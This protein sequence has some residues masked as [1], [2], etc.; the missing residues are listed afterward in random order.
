MYKE[1]CD[2]LGQH[3]YLRDHSHL[4]TF[5]AF[6]TPMQISCLSLH[7]YVTEEQIYR[8]LSGSQRGLLL[9]NRERLSKIILWLT[10]TIHIRQ[11]A[12]I[13]SYI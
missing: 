2:V 11:I 5:K 3:T 6:L 9:P 8:F 10:F 7:V 12:N 4:L 1:G 13:F